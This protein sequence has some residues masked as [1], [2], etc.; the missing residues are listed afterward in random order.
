MELTEG[1]PA[2][3]SEQNERSEA[4]SERDEESRGEHGKWRARD[5][6]KNL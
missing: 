1:S 2:E 4:L 5:G 6:E 3:S